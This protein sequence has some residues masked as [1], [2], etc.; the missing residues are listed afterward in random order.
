LRYGFSLVFLHD[1]SIYYHM[2]EACC[3]GDDIACWELLGM[4]QLVG[5]YVFL[6]YCYTQIL[7][8]V[9]GYGLMDCTQ[10]FV[11]VAMRCK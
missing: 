9:W 11:L 8:K 10:I 2:I 3:I 4:V 1:L 7:E 5:N 6:Q